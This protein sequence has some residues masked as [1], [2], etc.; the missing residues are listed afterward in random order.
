MEKSNSS[1][2]N[3]WSQAICLVSVIWILAFISYEHP[4][5][6]S[7]VWGIILVSAISWIIA[8]KFKS[9]IGVSQFE[10]TINNPKFQFS[11]SKLIFNVFSWVILIGYSVIN[12]N[13]LLMITA[14]SG[15][16]CA[17]LGYFALFIEKASL[18]STL[19]KKDNLNAN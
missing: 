12:P 4:M 18:Q 9:V 6:L 14:I 3:K 13:T 19:I 17:I 15:L 10:A 5:S 1:F 7:F 8:L 2:L 11:K 16:A